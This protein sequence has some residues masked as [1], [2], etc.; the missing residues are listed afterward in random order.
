MFT[1]AWEMKFHGVAYQN[2]LKKINCK[3]VSI[4]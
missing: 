4:R 3:R 2:N 1:Q